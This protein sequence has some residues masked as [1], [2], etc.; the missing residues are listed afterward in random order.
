MHRLLLTGTLVAAFGSAAIASVVLFRDTGLSDTELA[1]A[2]NL[3][4]ANL[5]K[6]PSDPSNAVADNAGAIALG[7]LLFSDTGMSANANVSCAT[8]HQEDRQFQDD[9]QLARGIGTTTRRTMPLRG[10]GYQSWF[11]W[12]GR[13]DSLWSQAIGPIESAVEHGFTRSQVA[14]HVIAT[15]R[16]RYARLFGSL[17]KLAD[18]PP[19]SP[20]GDKSQQANW[21]DLPENTRDEINRIFVNI[22]K[23][24]AAFE[25][26]LAPLENRFD[27]YVNAVWS[28]QTPS[29][30]A[31]LT[32]QEING[33]KV[34]AGKGQ[35]TNCHNGPRLTDEFFHNTGLAD[36]TTPYDDRGR[37]TAFVQLDSDPFTCAG[38]Y[39]DA[40]PESCGDLRFM[41][42]EFH[43]FDRTF[44]SPSL[45]GVT[46]RAPFMHAGQIGTLEQVIEHYNNAFPALLGQSEITP[47]GLSTREKAAL[48]AFLRTL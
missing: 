10:V 16:D 33:F 23:S 13:K 3:T 42:R 27:R 29:A 46:D 24:I 39:S 7:A 17:P 2:R 32:R 43:L 47:L 19:A 21:Q 26:T 11:F 31:M 8:C 5:P 44:K 22:G 14:I 34:F 40:E 4:L 6:M 9:Q 25:R 28:G 1:V 38:R 41:A 48:L 36:A 18:I 12:D 37:A 15:Y 35:C 20:M 45:R 30:G